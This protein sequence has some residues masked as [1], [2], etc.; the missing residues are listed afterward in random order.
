[1]RIYHAINLQKNKCLSKHILKF[2]P[3]CFWEFKT[4]SMVGRI[5]L[6]IAEISI[7]FT[8]SIIIKIQQRFSPMAKLFIR[9]VK[10]IDTIIDID[11]AARSTVAT[12]IKG[13]LDQNLL[14]T[15][16]KNGKMGV[17]S[18][19]TNPVYDRLISFLTNRK[20]PIQRAPY[21][22]TPWSDGVLTLERRT[23]WPY[24]R[25]WLLRIFDLKKSTTLFS[26]S[27]W[28]LKILQNL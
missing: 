4:I 2:R 26:Q 6:K 5:N 13:G 17:N 14:L 15:V 19:W 25:Y 10:T 11:H 18:I 27:Q 8:V 3:E 7:H 16:H 1:M 21:P 28:Q 20:F 12:H 24:D 23:E 9:K 22:I